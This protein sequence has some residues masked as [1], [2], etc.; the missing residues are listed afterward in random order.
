[1]IKE[2]LTALLWMKLPGISYAHCMRY[3]SKA[4]TLSTQ[5]MVVVCSVLVRRVYIQ[6]EGCGKLL[7][8]LHYP[9]V[10]SQ[11]GRSS[12]TVSTDEVELV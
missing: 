6:W 3:P 4:C 7:T 1:M 12:L 2:N 9:I 11:W 5:V 8:T 10:Y